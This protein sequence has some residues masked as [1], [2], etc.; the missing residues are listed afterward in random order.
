MTSRPPGKK[1]VALEPRKIRVPRTLHTG[2]G[3]EHTH[4]SSDYYAHVQV[5]S[6]HRARDSRSR[7]GL[8][9]AVT[10]DC[11]W[12]RKLPVLI[13]WKPRVRYRELLLFFP[14]VLAGREGHMALISS[15]LWTADIVSGQGQGGGLRTMGRTVHSRILRKRSL[16]I[17]KR[18][19]CS[20]AE[21]VFFSQGPQE[22]S[23]QPT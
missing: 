1:C 11:L 7:G 16:P 21:Y 9:P 19:P 12:E 8:G 18:R 6:T 22:I 17:N 5:A 15:T 4:G 2:P 13:F 14:L 20:K 3:T 23:K 10:A